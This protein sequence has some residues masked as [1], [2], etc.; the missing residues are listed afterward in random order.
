MCI[1][2]NYSRRGIPESTRTLAIPAIQGLEAGIRVSQRRRSILPFVVTRRAIGD[3]L[4]C[5][6]LEVSTL[7]T[8]HVGWYRG[9]GSIRSGSRRCHVPRQRHQGYVAQKSSSH[10]HDILP[11]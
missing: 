11:R 4:C 10:A 8:F 3:D 1:R 7:G 5:S 2:V 6:S 9:S